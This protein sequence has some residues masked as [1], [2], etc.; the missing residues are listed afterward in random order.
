M[1]RGWGLSIQ[2]DDLNREGEQQLG[3]TE[4]ARSANICLRCLVRAARSFL[5]YD[6]HN[7][8]VTGFLEELREAFNDYCHRFGDMDLVVR[9]DAIQLGAEGE[10]VYQETDKERSLA[11]RLYRDGVRRLM[12]RGRVD[13]DEL[14]G[15]LEVLSIRY[16]GLRQHEDDMVTLLRRADFQ[17]IELTAVQGFVSD[18]DTPSGRDDERFVEE[19]LARVE[20]PKNFDLPP[21]RLGKRKKISFVPVPEDLKARTAKEAH[22]RRLTLDCLSLVALLLKEAEQEAPE[23]LRL[24]DCLAFVEEIRDYLLIEGDVRGLLELRKLIGEIPQ[25]LPGRPGFARLTQEYGDPGSVSRLMRSVPPEIA[26]VPEALLRLLDS[27]PGD[28]PSVLMDLMHAEHSAPL[29]R[30]LRQALEPWVAERQVI[31]MQRIREDPGHGGADML[32]AL[33]KGAPEAARRLV[34]ELAVTG[35]PDIQIE[36]I[37]IIGRAN[38]GS[39]ARGLLLRLVDDPNARVRRRAAEALA[40]FHDNS[41]FQALQALTERKSASGLDANL[42]ETLGETL[43]SVDPHQALALFIGWVRPKGRLRLSKAGE[44]QLP[45]VAVAGLAALDDARANDTLKAFAERQRGDLARAATQARIRRARRL[46]GE[47]AT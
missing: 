6:A 21:P 1:H 22:P 44:D 39:T 38:Q 5:F 27:L 45:W 18:D 23:G 8:A 3:E 16:T 34:M 46:A 14:V 15:L 12:I 37:H 40:G 28:I 19:A 36:C 41:T 2:S 26:Q 17:A 11:F 43:A 7:N 31:L 33:S 24:Y 4:R 47:E 9:M 29:R 25:E 32:R 20:V 35:T 30:V 10:V 13:S 42:A